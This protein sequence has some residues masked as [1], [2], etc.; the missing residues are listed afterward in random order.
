MLAGILSPSSVSLLRT[1]WKDGDEDDDD[2]YGDD[3]DDDY[4]YRYFWCLMFMIRSFDPQVAL[5]IE[6]LPDK[7][8][9]SLNV[10]PQSL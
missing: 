9:T 8:K 7:R 10:V 5:V 1:L 6:P 2:D 3:D 4:G